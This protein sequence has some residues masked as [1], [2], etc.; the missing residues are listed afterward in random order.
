MTYDD[1]IAERRK[2][3]ERYDDYRVHND[4]EVA[5]LAADPD[6]VK[7]LAYA[8]RVIAEARYLHVDAFPR[9]RAELRDA[10]Q[11]VLK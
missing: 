7:R 3:I 1:I 2:A 5:V 9:A 11:A 6:A 10:L 8:L 4:L